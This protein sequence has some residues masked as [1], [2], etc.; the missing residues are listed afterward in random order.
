VIESD[1]EAESDIES[2]LSDQGEE[3]VGD[4]INVGDGLGTSAQAQACR[5]NIGTFRRSQEN[6]SSIFTAMVDRHVS[7]IYW[8]LNLH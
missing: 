1:E 4:S 2:L 6:S 7:A 5:Q 3:E 8:T